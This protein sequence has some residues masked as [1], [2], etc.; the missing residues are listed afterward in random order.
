MRLKEKNQAIEMRK[1]G[2]SYSEIASSMNNVPKSTLSSWLQGVELTESQKDRI[3]R[4]VSNAAAR[5]RVKGA[6]TNRDKANER[7]KLIQ[8]GAEKT[9]EQLKGNPLFMT[10]IALYW[11]EGT[12]KSRW[13][14]F[15]NSDPLMIR[16]MMQWLRYLN[17]ADE[18]IKIRLYIHEIYKDENCEKFWLDIC[19]LPESCILKTVYKPNSHVVKKNIDYKGCCRIEISKS[20]IYWKIDRWIRILI[21]EILP[22]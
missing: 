15:T 8:E 11:A 20:E 2:M 6:W 19:N 9:F 14:Q 5:G 17:V 18:L 12:K 1:R 13:F 3:L 10:G 7:I 4:K 22:S 21:S 16:L